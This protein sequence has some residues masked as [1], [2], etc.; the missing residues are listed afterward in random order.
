MRSARVKAR[1]AGWTTTLL[2]LVL[3]ACAASAGASWPGG[4]GEIAY[5]SAE[6]P[7]DHPEPQG[8]GIH[9]QRVGQA[10]R[11]L[12]ADPS[13]RNPA[14]SPDGRW[15]VFSRGTA[16]TNRYRI[17][18]RRAIFLMRSDGSGLR[19]LTDGAS[20]DLDPSFTADGRRVL[21]ARSPAGGYLGDDIYSVDVDG[22]GLR[23]LVAG[24]ATE[25]HPVA[26]PNGRIVAFER[27]RG[28]RSHVF[29]MRPNGTRF[30]NATRRLPRHDDAYRPEFHP[31]GRRLAYAHVHDG[32]AQLFAVRPNGRR[33][34]RLTSSFRCSGCPVHRS[35]AFSP[36]GR[37]L[38][39]AAARNFRAFLVLAPLRRLRAVRPLPD[40]FGGRRNVIEPAW[41]P[42][43]R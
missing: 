19:P 33:P 28:G 23:R 8:F 4:N 25:G 6:I 35:A 26:S 27:R 24:P 31:S 42:L 20:Q 21:F 9:L 1:R 15:I 29:T 18:P 3:L 22:G 10:P 2:A 41:R 34:R 14:F 7:E 13:D 16:P 17:P 43:P 37:L 32:R 39:A 36:D 12:T 40:G 38:L 5:V 11:R 30:H